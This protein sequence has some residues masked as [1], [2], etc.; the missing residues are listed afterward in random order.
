MILSASVTLLTLPG[1]D[2]I[3]RL[4]GIIAILF[5]ASSMVSAVAALFR[6]KADVERSVV[7][8]GGEGLMV[9]SVCTAALR[10]HC[11]ILTSL[12]APEHRHVLARRLP[13]MGHRCIH[14]RH[15]VLLVQRRYSHE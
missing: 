14:H 12:T 13:R 15:H 6:Y 5:S 10:L 8:V 9:M 3:A 4:G 1:L 2:D 7:Y 11:E